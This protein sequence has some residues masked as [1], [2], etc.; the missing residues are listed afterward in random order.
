MKDTDRVEDAMED[1]ELDTS[2]VVLAA[3][4]GLFDGIFSGFLRDFRDGIKEKKC[5]DGMGEVKEEIETV[6]RK[7]GELFRS[8]KKLFDSEEHSWYRVD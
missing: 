4:F 8:M 6:A 5:Q 1:T 3:L 2:A 7:T